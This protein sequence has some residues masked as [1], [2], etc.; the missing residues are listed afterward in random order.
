MTVF[1][2]TMVAPP[3]HRAGV[4]VV[5]VVRVRRAELFD[6]GA[7][8][9]PGRAAELGR[10]G[11]SLA[12]RARVAPAGDA[13]QTRGVV[14][15]RSR[16]RREFPLHLLRELGERLVEALVRRGGWGR[17][18]GRRLTPPRAPTRGRATPPR[19]RG[20]APG[21]IAGRGRASGAGR[22]VRT[23]RVD[24]RRAPTQRPLPAVGVRPARTRV[25][26]QRHPAPRHAG[27]HPRA[28]RRAPTSDETFSNAPDGSLSDEV[29]IRHLSPNTR[30]DDGSR[31]VDQ[32]HGFWIIGDATTRKMISTR[33]TSPLLLSATATAPPRPT[34]AASPSLPR[35]PRPPFFPPAP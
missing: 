8:G 6:E 19:R 16:L 34:A 11:E 28:T 23:R 33:L 27:L 21:R 1:V 25:R 4:G 20:D 30:V 5:V 2:M 31:F 3:V 13:R 14:A 9:G 32:R 7:D 15:G 29:P 10:G 24:Y 35:L 22:A 18:G 26:R 12:A 17:V